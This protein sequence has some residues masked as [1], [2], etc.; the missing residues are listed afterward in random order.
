M[1]KASNLRISEYA[2]EADSNPLKKKN[3][4]GVILP[5]TLRVFKPMLEANESVKKSKQVVSQCSCQEG[6]WNNGSRQ[7]ATT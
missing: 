5:S 3:P 6:A 2:A 1:G 4:H 7:Q